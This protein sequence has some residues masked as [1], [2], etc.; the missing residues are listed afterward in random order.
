M[1][2]TFGV[3][4]KKKFFPFFGKVGTWNLYV[5]W[6]NLA[7]S[8]VMAS[9]QFWCYV[10]GWSHWT[11]LFEIF[12]CISLPHL[13]DGDMRRRGDGDGEL[14]GET[15]AIFH[16]L[17]S[18]HGDFWCDQPMFQRVQLLTLENDRRASLCHTELRRY[19]TGCPPGVFVHSRKNRHLEKSRNFPK[20]IQM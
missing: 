5:N 13:C 7:E 3:P 10:A 17:K 9:L 6:R 4:P 19:L 20:I 15:W 11:D 1:A 18:Q 16:H 14:D 8:M 2:A 12:A